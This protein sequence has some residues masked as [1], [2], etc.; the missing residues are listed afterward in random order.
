MALLS[1]TLRGIVAA[2][3]L[4]ALVAYASP[5]DNVKRDSLSSIPSGWL[6]HEDLPSAETMITLQVGLKQQKVDKLIE[7]LYEVSDPDH[8]RYGNHLS[9]EQVEA[10]VQP[11]PSSLAAV[12][13]WLTSCGVDPA[14]ATR[15]PAKDW[16]TVTVPISLAEQLV[17]AK[18]RTFN[19]MESKRKVVRSL[20]YN[21]PASVSEHID[22]IHPT[23]FFG[24]SSLTVTT[25]SRKRSVP[26]ES[27]SLNSTG[28]PCTSQPFNL[29]TP[30]CLMHLYRFDDYVP[31]A[32]SKNRLGVVNYEG[33]LA[34]N[35]D[36]QSFFTQFRPDAVNSTFGIQSVGGGIIST[37]F[38]SDEASLDVQWAM[39]LTSPTPV[40]VY[41]VG[42]HAED[43][44]DVSDPQGDPFLGWALFVLNQTT[45]PQVFTTS[46][47]DTESAV[48]VDYA[49][50]LCNTFAQLG[51]RGISVIFGS[52]DSGVD[53]DVDCSAVTDTTPFQPSFPGGCPFFTSVGGT[54]GINPEFGVGGPVSPPSNYRG[55]GGGFSNKI[56][57]EN[58]Q[59]FPRPSYQDK[60]V[61]A[62]LKNLGSTYE[63]LFNRSGR[64]YPDI[65]AQSNNF[66]I[67]LDGETDGDSGT[68]ASGP[69]VAAVISLLNDFLLSKGKPPLGFINPWLYSKGFKGLN[70]ILIGQS[71]GCNGRGFNSSTG[72]DPV[73]GLGTPDFLNLQRLL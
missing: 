28:D 32:A 37:N 69:V 52:G 12:D 65:A 3:T 30:A 16:L 1:P 23:T 2:W 66:A 26:L 59:V 13:D 15:S 8:K 70:D 41:S 51:A 60:A 38:S 63:G 4:F 42:S 73:T 50:R 46:Y 36:L 47:A 9:K 22:V 11:H 31:R 40:T 72:W 57:S 6:M 55:S 21:L 39:G 10:L 61:S 54:I 71:E 45:P 62:Y 48:P 58:I 7:A 64:A 27:G 35:S 67:V 5:V 18:Y 29:I 53:N 44:L 33:D 68:S 49:K 17:N 34:V 43:G 56:T 19:H 20:E 14:S 25:P 24:S